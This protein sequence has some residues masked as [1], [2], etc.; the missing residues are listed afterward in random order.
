MLDGW[1]VA[2]PSDDDRPPNWENAK[3]ML[4]STSSASPI[5]RATR[6]RIVILGGGFAGVTVAQAL[7][8]HLQAG[9]ANVVLVSRDNAFVYYPL[10]PEIVP[11]QIRIE[12]ILSP[13]RLVAPHARLLMG[14]VQ[15]IDL[16]AQLV[17]VRYGLD[18]GPTDELI[19]PYDHL[20]LALGGIPATFNIPGINEYTYQI[21]RLGHAFALRNHLIDLLE[22][23]EATNDRELRRALL[24]VVVIGGGATG[25]E[26]AAAVEE[27]LSRA[28]H[29]YR[30]LQQSDYRVVLVHALERL[31]PEAPTA[32]GDYAERMLHRRGIDLLLNRPVVQVEPDAVILKDG[33]RIAAH[34]VIS[35]IGVQPHPLARALPVEHD[36]QGRIVV[37]PTL[38][39]PAYPNVWAIGDLAAVPDPNTGNTYPP[40][41]QHAIAEAETAAHNIAATLRGRPLH[42]IQ[43]RTRGQMVTLGHRTAVAAIAGRVITG[44]FAWWIWRTYHLLRLPRWERRLRVLFDWTLDL[45]FPPELVRLPVSPLTPRANAAAPVA[46]PVSA[47]ANP[48]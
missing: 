3:D 30:G 5:T 48:R 14:S 7:E 33:T 19:L 45:F 44:H 35:A 4:V 42:A 37:E 38:R 20:V 6:P 9:E 13:I 46:E 12:D 32:L 27:L 24:T 18:H 11:G 10:L 39:I 26:L 25:V 34:T 21:Q 15:A 22:Q 36:R 43:Y 23:A 8:H 40:T 16:D 41:A 2:T 31:L 28:L 29:Y 47:P 1:P 17:H